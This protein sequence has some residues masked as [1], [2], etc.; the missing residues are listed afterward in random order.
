MLNHI[1]YRKFATLKSGKRLI[2]RCLYEQDYGELVDL[3]QETPDEDMQ[4]LNYDLKG[5]KAVNYWLGLLKYPQVIPLV[6]VDLENKRLIAE[7]DL[8]RGQGSTKHIGEIK[9]IFVSRPFQGLGVGSLLLEELIELSAKEDLRWLKAEVVAE[10]KSAIKAFRCK[11]FKIK[12]TLEDFFISRD[13][14]IHDVV[15]MSRPVLNGNE[16]DE[17]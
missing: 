9:Q 10:H 13:G 15:L 1:T 17:F 4:F 2:F 6:A 11:G 14:S 7:A 16:E 3:F 8:Q 12:T 5:P